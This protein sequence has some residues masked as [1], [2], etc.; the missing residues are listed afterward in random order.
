M[1]LTSI[2]IALFLVFTACTPKKRIYSYFKDVPDTVSLYNITDTGFKALTIKVDDLLQINVTSPNS[3]ANIYFQ[4]PGSNLSNGSVNSAA[5]TPIPNTYL[6][7][8]DGNV[9]I[10][11]IGRIMLRGLTMNQAKDVITQKLLTYLK[12]PIVTVR[13]QNF[14][15]TVLGEVIR[16]ASYYVSNERVSILDALGMAGDLTVYGR[17]ENVLLIREKDGKKSLSR[18]NLTS[19]NIFQSPYYYLQQNDIVYVEASD[20][21][22]ANSD[23]TTIRTITL[24]MSLL[25]LL[26]VL[27]TRIL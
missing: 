3:E 17:R 22:L 7:D 24:S 9:D 1:K 21:K 8:K 5:G 14:K 15:I 19:S 18:V 25:S 16:P 20:L 23:R 6:V 2:I 13:L 11:L 10:P 26:A 4:T 27:L 12:E